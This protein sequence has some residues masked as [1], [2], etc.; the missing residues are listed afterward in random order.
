LNDPQWEEFCKGKLNYLETKWTKRLEDYTSEDDPS[1][2]H[3][4]DEVNDSS[5]ITHDKTNDNSG[6]EGESEEHHHHERQAEKDRFI[7]EAEQ[8]EKNEEDEK[9]NE[10]MV[11]RLENLGERNIKKGE[12][13]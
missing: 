9:E 4:T 1:S 8:R 5:N 12:K 7:R 6:G 13:K 3:I 11:K 10:E 2:E